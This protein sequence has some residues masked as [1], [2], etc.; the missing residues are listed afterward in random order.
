MAYRKIHRP[1]A[2]DSNYVEL[3]LKPQLPTVS[4]H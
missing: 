3:L 2:L 4:D 1:I